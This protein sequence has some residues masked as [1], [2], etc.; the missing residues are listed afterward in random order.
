V[1]K[2][3]KWLKQKLPN[4]IMLGTML[5]QMLQSKLIRG[6][7]EEVK[8]EEAIPPEEVPIGPGV[9]MRIESSS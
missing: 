5:A 6:G 7:L 1:D 4:L 2:R 9:S 3:E 8:V